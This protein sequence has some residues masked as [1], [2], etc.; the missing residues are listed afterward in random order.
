MV[1]KNRPRR[2]KKDPVRLSKIRQTSQKSSSFRSLKLFKL[3]IDSSKCKSAGECFQKVFQQILRILLRNF[4]GTSSSH[5]L[6]PVETDLNYRRPPAGCCHGEDS[7]LG[8]VN[9]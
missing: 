6:Q 8:T 2:T 4:V 7:S 5:Q 1:S 3:V 9:F